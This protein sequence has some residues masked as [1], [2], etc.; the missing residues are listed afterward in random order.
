MVYSQFD[1][2][3]NLEVFNT[4][5]TVDETPV[6]KTSKRALTTDDPNDVQFIAGATIPLAF[7]VWNGSN[8][9]RNGMKGISTW[10]TAQISK[11]L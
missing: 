1:E 2:L 5:G 4:A 3:P 9:E 8:V 10:L 6:L 11:N 7:A